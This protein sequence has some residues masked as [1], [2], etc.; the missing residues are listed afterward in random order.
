MEDEYR[1][2]SPPSWGSTLSTGLRALVARPGMGKVLKPLA[3]RRSRAQ[4]VPRDP[5]GELILVRR[6]PR[7]AFRVVENQMNYASLGDRLR[8][9]AA[10][11][12]PIFLAEICARADEATITPPTRALLGGS[13]LA[14]AEFASSHALLDYTTHR[15]LWRWYS[16]ARDE[17]RRTQ[18]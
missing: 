17:H 13:N 4:R 8:P 3:G 2:P 15:L 12:F 6:E 5:L 1:G 14:A 10:E 18:S 9:S 16:Q 11:N 7:M